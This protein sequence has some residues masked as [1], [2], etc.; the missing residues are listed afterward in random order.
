MPARLAVLPE[1]LD[2][3]EIGF[4]RDE[5]D[6]RCR[7]ELRRE[8]RWPVGHDGVAVEIKIQQPTI[9][10]VAAGSNGLR[11]RRSGVACPFAAA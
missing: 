5:D 8:L 11:R 6:F 1:R 7:N 9:D 4:S 3:L 2:F 10:G